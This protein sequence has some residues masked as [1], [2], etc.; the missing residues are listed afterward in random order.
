MTS[1]M[2]HQQYHRLTAFALRKTTEDE[3]LREGLRAYGLA[4]Y[5][6]YQKSLSLPITISAPACLTRG[7]DIGI[8]L[9]KEWGVVLIELSL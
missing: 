8:L 9:K 6:R 3:Y 5:Q 1:V 2:E 4:Y 7:E